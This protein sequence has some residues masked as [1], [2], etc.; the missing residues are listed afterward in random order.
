M[1]TPKLGQRSSFFHATKEEEANV[2]SILHGLHWTTPSAIAE[3]ASLEE[4]TE[5]DPIL[6]HG[7]GTEPSPSRTTP[8]PASNSPETGMHTQTV[9]QDEEVGE[10]SQTQSMVEGTMPLSQGLDGPETDE[11]PGTGS[12]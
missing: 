10:R 3:E 2:V 6:E 12:T 4:Q 11:V 5:A 9:S 7:Q 8:T 1:H